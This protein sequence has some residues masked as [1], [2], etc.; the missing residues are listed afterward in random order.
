MTEFD[1]VWL[2][3]A[4]VSGLMWIAKGV[5]LALGFGLVGWIADHWPR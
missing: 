5:C 1:F 4:V 3:V 2:L